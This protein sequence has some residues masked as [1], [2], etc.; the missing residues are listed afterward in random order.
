[1]KPKGLVDAASITSHMSIPRRS[2]MIAASFT[3]AMFTA[4]KV[5]SRIFVNS[6]TSVDETGTTSFTKRR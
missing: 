1:M 4:L 2:A 6:A 3:R 5:F